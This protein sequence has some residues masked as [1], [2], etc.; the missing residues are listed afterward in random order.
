V[1]VAPNISWISPESENYETK[2]ALPG[3]SWGFLA[4]ITLTENYFVKTGFSL[5]YL[6]GKLEYPHKQKI[7]ED[8]IEPT[9]GSL[10][11][12]YNLRYIELPVSLK[13]RTNK[14]GKTAFFGEIGFGVS[15]NLRAHANDTFSPYEIEGSVESESDIKDDIALIK[16]SLIAAAGIEY[17]IDESVS[18]ITSISFNNGLTNILNGNN[19]IDTSVKQRANLYYFHLNIGIM[20]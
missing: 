9:E 13:M 2:A 4:D 18:L 10:S 20:F 15:F 5:D 19:E 11:R 12:K 3:F 16:G 6:N 7:F 14:F 17:F 1:R 8:D